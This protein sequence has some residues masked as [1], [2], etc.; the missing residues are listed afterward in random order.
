MVA[1]RDVVNSEL[2][3]AVERGLRNLAADEGVDAARGGRVDE[4]LRGAG[5]PGNP[6]DRVIAAGRAPDRGV[7]QADA[8]RLELVDRNPS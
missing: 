7:V 2:A 3:R 6:L 4:T 1:G 8:T 5:A